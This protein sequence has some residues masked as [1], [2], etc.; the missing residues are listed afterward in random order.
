M[1]RLFVSFVS[2]A[3]VLAMQCSAAD[4]S[5]GYVLLDDTAT[6]L[7]EDFNRAKGSVRLLFVID[8]TCPGCLRG[9]EEL[10]ETLL[11]KTHDPRLQTFIVHVP[12][13]ESEAKDVAPVMKR[14]QNASVRHYWNP[15]GAFGDQLGQ[16]LGLRHGDEAVYAWDVWLA[17]DAD[18]SWDEALAPRPWLF[19]HQLYWLLGNEEFRGLD[20][21]A[22]AAEV[23]QLLAQLP[24]A[25]DT[26]R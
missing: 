11:S 1:H 8:P 18:A 15:S 13:L 25:A 10:N 16:A 22:F 3:V 6:Q 17:Y 14:V 5:S 4:S 21:D 26:A 20:T 2:L 19:M 12:V 24:A 7:R 9:L 23:R